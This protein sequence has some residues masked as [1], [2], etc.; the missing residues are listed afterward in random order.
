[1]GSPLSSFLAEAVMQ[2][3]ESKA[4]TNNDDIK[5]W[6]RYVDDVLATV[7]KNKTDDIVLTIN[8]TTKNIKF[9]KEEEH[10]N[11][12]AFLDV[13]ITKTDKGTLTT[14]VYRKK[15]HTDQILNYNSNHAT[16]HK[17]SCIKTLLNRIDTHSNIDQSKQDERKYLYSTF[18]KNDYPLEFINKMLQHKHQTNTDRLNQT[19]T[20]ITLP[21]IQYTLPQK[22]QLDSS[23]LLTLTL[24]TNQHANLGPTSLNTKTRH[25]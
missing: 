12:L 2:D 6:D 24:H 5:T 15:T 14:Q 16:Q 20:R 11:K 18:Y 25:I 17:V 4:V 7:K 10:D 21:Y 19:N 1:M 22:W 13:L 23:N 3:L 9:T 8:N